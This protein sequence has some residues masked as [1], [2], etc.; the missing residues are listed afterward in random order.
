MTSP[1]FTND[2]IV[3]A[4]KLNT[5]GDICWKLIARQLG[6]DVDPERLRVSVKRARLRGTIHRKVRGDYRRYV[7]SVKKE[8]LVLAYELHCEGYHW[9][10][11]SEG[12]GIS[13]SWLR[14]CLAKA[15]RE[16]LP[17]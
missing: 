1:N 10:H 11:I 8:D 15:M 6:N 13:S 9:R 14:K 17:A 4:Y 7:S 16:G 12:L 3:Q 5:Q 2:Q